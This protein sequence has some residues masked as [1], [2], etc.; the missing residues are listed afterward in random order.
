MRVGQTLFPRGPKTVRDQSR[1]PDER[2][3]IKE[4]KNSPVPFK[5]LE[6]PFH[7]SPQRSASKLEVRFIP[8]ILL[9][10]RHAS[11]PVYL[12]QR[13]IAHGFH[14]HIRERHTLSTTAFWYFEYLNLINGS[15]DHL[16]KRLKKLLLCLLRVLV[17]FD[18]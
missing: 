17:E 15:S 14:F 16:L 9:S 4:K 8:E 12:S 1:R 10:R 13:M 2:T 7:P 5:I 3:T 6:I 11:Q 18:P